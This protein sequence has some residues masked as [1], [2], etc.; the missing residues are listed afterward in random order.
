MR[1]WL[2]ALPLLLFGHATWAAEAIRGEQAL[3]IETRPGVSTAF[4]L[5]EPARPPVVAAILLAGGDGS[6]GV[7][8]GETVDAPVAFGRGNFLVRTR[9]LLAGHGVLAMTMDA[10]SDQ[11]RS[12]TA[13]FRLSQEHADD[14]AALAAWLKRRSGGLPVWLVGTSMGTLSAANVAVRL[15]AQVDGVILT[16]SITR[17]HR[18]YA[19]PADG[20]FGLG[21][22]GVGV[23]AM[24][25][26]HS[27][28]SCEVTP[29]GDAAG[30]LESLANSPRRR[31]LMVDGGAPARSAA[32]QAMSPHGFF[33][34]EDEV[35][36]A[37]AEF[38][39]HT[40]PR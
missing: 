1:G 12:L 2:M 40:S 38:M 11:G 26:A 8:P 13:Q 34:R 32:C 39:T 27:G 20:V 18:K 25:V 7:R 4:Y 28:D 3:E 21:L 22:G 14:I 17:G 31:L 9:G 5:T 33:G 6:V 30:L 10:P 37:M 24:V 23:P 15:G 35:V 19:Y 16:S 36:A 29:P